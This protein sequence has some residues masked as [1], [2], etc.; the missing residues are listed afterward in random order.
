MRELRN[1]LGLT[2]TKLYVRLRKYD[3]FRT[4]ALTI[5]DAGGAVVFG[6]RPGD[7]FP[8]ARG[9]FVVSWIFTPE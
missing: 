7:R 8:N 5:Y 1:V 4:D 3:R 2:R 9:A 6:T